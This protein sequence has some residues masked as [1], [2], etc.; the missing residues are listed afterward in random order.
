MAKVSKMDRAIAE[1]AQG[2]LAYVEDGSVVEVR[3]CGFVT[4]LQEAMRKGGLDPDDNEDDGEEEDDG[5]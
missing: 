3:E 2:L 4:E 1:F 5:D